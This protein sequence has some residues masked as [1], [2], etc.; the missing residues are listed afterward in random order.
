[1]KTFVKVSHTH[2]QSVVLK[3]IDFIVHPSSHELGIIAIHSMN[4]LPT[5]MSTTERSENMNNELKKYNNI[6]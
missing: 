4:T 1:M 6:K 3:K 5:Q 2:T